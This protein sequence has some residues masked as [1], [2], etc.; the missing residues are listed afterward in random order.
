MKKIIITGGIASGK[1]EATRVFQTLGVPLIDSDKIA[2]DLLV[3]HAPAY[4]ETLEHFGTSILDANQHI[5]RS[6]LGEIIFS[7]PFEKA[8]LENL[9]H[10]LVLDKIKEKI[11]KLEQTSPPP[12]YCLIDIPLYAEIILSEKNKLKKEFA[13]L[14]DQILV[15]DLDEATQKKRLLSRYHEKNI[16]INPDKI[17]AILAAQ[18]TR[19]DRNTLATHIIDNHLDLIQLKNAVLKLHQQYNRH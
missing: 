10:P 6:K 16:K 12:V 2:H 13:S 5:N 11:K 4:Q 19:A 3:I 9:L 7:N 1:T 18:A 14:S 8:W 15:I 17:N